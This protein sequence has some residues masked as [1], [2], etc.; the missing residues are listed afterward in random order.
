MSVRWMTSPRALC[1]GALLNLSFAA[2]CSDRDP[3][4]TEE[5]PVET[6]EGVTCGIACCTA[7]ERCATGECVPLD[8]PC[9]SSEDCG[10]DEVCI[11]RERRCVSR[12]EFGECR[13]VP[14]TGVFRPEIE[15]S[16]RPREDDPHARYSNVVMAPAVANLTDDDGDGRTGPGDVP[17]MAFIAFDMAADG[18]C[19]N[20][21]VLR[22][23]S[24]ACE[25]GRLPEL[26]TIVNDPET[27]ERF[28]FDNSAGI[29]I[30]DLDPRGNPDDA[31]PEIVVVMKTATSGQTMALRRVSDDGREWAVM[32]RN[33]EYPSFAHFQ[34]SNPQ[35][36]GPQPSIADVD[37][38]GQAEV[39]IGN[40]VLDG[41]TGE[42]VWDGLE[43]VGPYAG[44]G[45][46]GFLGPISV[47]ADIDLDGRNELI[48]GDTIY[49]AATGALRATLDWGTT[50]GSCPGVGVRCD[51][52]VGIANF[53]DDPQAEIVS[54]RGSEVGLFGAH[55]TRRALVQLPGGPIDNEGGPP[56]IADFDGDGRL[57][58]G[59]AGA[60]FYTVIDF[61]CQGT[62]LPAYCHSEMIRWVHPIQDHSSRATGSSVFDFEGDGRAEVVYA[63]ERSFF[64][65][66]GETGEALFRDDT[67][68]SNTRLELPVVVD[69]DAD[70]QAEV[71]VA[72]AGGGGSM[73]G[74]DV[75]GDADRNWVRTRRIW[76]QQAYFIGNVREFGII[77][78]YPVQSF[79]DPARNSFRQNVYAGNVHDA[80]DLVVSSLG[81]STCGNEEIAEIGFFVENLGV[82]WVGAGVRIRVQVHP[83]DGAPFDL[84]A[85]YTPHQ[86]DPGEAVLLTTSFDWHE[87][88]PGG[89]EVVV[90]ADWEPE[91]DGRGRYNEC[92]ET[93]NTAVAS[94]HDRCLGP[95]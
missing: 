42:L 60:A 66:D 90:T 93:N 24:G 88:A 74:I 4:G 68:R 91:S 1:L 3:I 16:Y 33:R 85:M 6:C 80:P 17:D 57:E 51:G 2:A 73:V 67:H 59:V 56:T 44:V 21:G 23:V 72:R 65:F 71:I 53:D 55:G 11:V 43:T 48:A 31:V 63:D 54:V 58:I 39:I 13:Y 37:S 89:F 45:N 86:L 26:A 75:F 84:P 38:D 50:G 8:A 47:V 32:W 12:A 49:D 27:G 79:T 64:I 77:P 82:A 81:A 5:P 25:G 35:H 76:N 22:I 70:G 28:L 14:P 29:A 34:G 7:G 61:D 19:T 41:Q 30:G 83:D 9:F 78:T 15:C 36:G 18:C 10:E 95:G 52:F 20:Q 46:N 69:L 62:P 40:V 87:R 92:D 94:F